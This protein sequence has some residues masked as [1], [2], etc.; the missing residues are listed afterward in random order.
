MKSKL[1][2]QLILVQF[3]EQLQSSVHFKSCLLHLHRVH[4]PLQPHLISSRHDFDASGIVIQTGVISSSVAFQPQSFGSYVKV[5][6]SERYQ[7]NLNA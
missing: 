5:L 7:I 6:K 2:I 1:I 3:A 4:S